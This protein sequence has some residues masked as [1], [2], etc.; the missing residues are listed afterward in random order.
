MPSTASPPPTAKELALVA[1]IG[2]T[3]ARFALMA[4]GGHDI[5]APLILACADF[6]GLAE[7][8]EAYLKKTAPAARPRLAAFDAAGPV[9]GDVVALTNH[10]WRIE[11]S[12]VSRALG[13]ERL[14]IINDF[15]A[16]AYAVPR[17]TAAD[18]AT[19]RAGAKDAHGPIALIGPGTGLGVAAVIPNGKGGWLRIAS[20]GGHV[21]MTAADDRDDAIL[22]HL[23]RRFDHVSAERVLSGQGLINLHEAISTLSGEAA[24]TLTP[25]QIAERGQAGDPICKEALDRF[26]A[27]LGTVAGNL[28]L[29]VGAQGGVVIAGGIVPRY[30]KEIAASDFEK[31][32]LDKGR[33][34]SYLEPIPVH[35]V[36]HPLPAFIGLAGLLGEMVDEMTNTRELA[37]ISQ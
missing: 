16:L 20:E 8:A 19:L 3:N 5:V 21:T 2:G 4:P 37:E 25:E 6:P 36:T 32:F 33:M 1:D 24:E 26:F 15:A 7:A 14:D 23:R 29:T 34:R 35:V 10:P 31:R 27:M 17:L 12:A 11:I 13:L 22:A 30:L 18:R 9:V 28:A